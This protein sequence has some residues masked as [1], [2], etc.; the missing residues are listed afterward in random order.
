MVVAALFT[1]DC[2]RH[3]RFRGPATCYFSRLRE[4]LA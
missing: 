2:Y 3:G 1:L 4:N